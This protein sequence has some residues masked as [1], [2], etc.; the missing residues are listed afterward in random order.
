MITLIIASD[1]IIAIYMR[2]LAGYFYLKR[3]LV[4]KYLIKLYTI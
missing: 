3:D 4:L 2:E 1:I